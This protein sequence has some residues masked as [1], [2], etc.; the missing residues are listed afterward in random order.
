MSSRLALLVSAVLLC[1]GCKVT[2]DI[3]TPCL[4]VKKGT[5]TDT[6]PVVEEDLS[7]GQDFISFGSLDC[8]DL[9]CV[10][11]ADMPLETVDTTNNAGKPVKQ[12]KGYCSKACKDDSTLLQDPCAV[13]DPEAVASVKDRMS[14]RALLLDQTAL[15]ELRKNDPDRFHDIFG[16]N[17]SPFFCAG[18]PTN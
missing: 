8:E 18:N 17:N 13:T 10:K 2:S 1:G 16:D 12:V 11:D 5:G 6:A 3:G 9:V 14:C 4:L 7:P 15:D